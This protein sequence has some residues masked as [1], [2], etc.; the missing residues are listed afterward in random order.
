MPNRAPSNGVSVALITAGATIVANRND[1]G[2]LLIVVGV[3]LA[4]RKAGDR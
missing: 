1:V 3:V 2:W 4:R